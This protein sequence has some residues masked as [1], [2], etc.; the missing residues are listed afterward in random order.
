VR[1]YI[2]DRLVGVSQ[3]TE[4]EPLRYVRLGLNFKSY[5][6]FWYDDVRVL[7]ARPCNTTLQ[8]A[9]GDGDVDHAGELQ[10]QRVPPRPFAQWPQEQQTQDQAKP[11]SSHGS[12]PST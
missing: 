7:A 5:D 8:D 4:G 3:R 1:F 12:S 11:T 9:D 10:C 2:D 6:N